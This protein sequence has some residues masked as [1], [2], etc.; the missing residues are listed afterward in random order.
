MIETTQ[1]RT[2]L[3]FS[4]F[5]IAVGYRLWGITNPLLDF[6]SWR[7]TGTASIARNFYEE[8]MNIFKPKLDTI[9]EG[10]KTLSGVEFQLYPYLVALFYFLFGVHEI[11]GRIVSIL[12][13]LGAMGYLYLL[14]KKYF[15]EK[16]ALYA[17]FFYA[18]LPMMVYYTRTFQP[19]SAM[20]FFSISALYHF[21]NWIQTEK[22]GQLISAA[23]LSLCS[24]LV[25]IPT[26]Y[27]LFPMMFLSVRK[28]GGRII[29]QGALYIFLIVTLLPTIVWYNESPKIIGSANIFEAEG[30]WAT[31]SIL[32]NPE[33]YQQIFLSRIA[34]KMFAF[35][36]FPLLLVGMFL[37]PERKEQFLFHVWFFAVILYIFVVAQGNYHH[38]Y[39]QLPIILPGVV[40]MGRGADFLIGAVQRC[41][42]N[43]HRNVLF[44][45][46]ILMIFFIPVHSI[47]K[48]SHRLVVDM[49]VMALA[50]QLKTVSRQGDLVIVNDNGEP[51]ILYYSHRKGWHV[52][53]DLSP[54][55]LEKKKEKG[56]KFF[57][58]AFGDFSEKNKNLYDFLQSNYEQVWHGGNGYIFSLKKIEK[59]ADG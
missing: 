52:E 57:L 19:E 42:K 50:D 35:T 17:S 37:K 38:E 16:V 30:K 3:F 58:T 24:F 33:F 59:K 20:I 41:G 8:G 32:L 9:N 56:A 39:Y 29:T 6:H 53:V 55:E 2:L 28:Y 12:F 23:F 13:G 10:T 48:L 47:Y 46:V 14:A 1:K 7:Q 51:E 5:V 27:M 45:A 26:L 31:L 43:W 44:L 21:D 40:F 49:N 54:E 18:V 36:G 22:K 15:E 11:I 4:I 25:K 34:E